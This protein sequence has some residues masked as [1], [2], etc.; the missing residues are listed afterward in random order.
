MPATAKKVNPV[1]FPRE[2]TELLLSRINFQALA[3][4]KFLDMGTGS[5]IIGIRASNAGAKVTAVDI[6]P[7]A[8]NE[9]GKNAR[10]EK[11]KIGFALSDLFSRLKGKFDFIAFNPPYVPSDKIKWLDT[12]GGKRGREVLDRFL[13]E[14]PTHLNPKGKCFFLQ[15]SL[16]GKIKTERLLRKAGM[17]FGIVGK[18]KLFFE[19][20]LVYEASRKNQSES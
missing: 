20:L 5:G 16:N 8:L 10:R 11:A 6:N 15:T 7:E 4:K 17:K 18:K 12:D 13:A 19:E 9:A 2:D 1:Y 3:G 14:F